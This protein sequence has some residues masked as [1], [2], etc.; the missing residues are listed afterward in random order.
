M[1]KFYSLSLYLNIIVSRGNVR[2]LLAIF[3]RNGDWEGA[4]LDPQY[5]GITI[6]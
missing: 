6:T 1:L 3:S 2:H 5:S 4:I